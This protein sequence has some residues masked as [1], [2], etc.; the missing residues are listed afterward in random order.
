[1]FLYRLIDKYYRLRID[2]IGLSLF[3]IA[4]SSVVLLEVLQLFYFRA[5]VYAPSSTQTTIELTAWIVVVV[6]LI[7]GLGTRPATILNYAFTLR[8][9]STLTDWEYH[10]DYGMT[11]MNFILMF[12]PVSRVL[13]VDALWRHWRTRTLAKQPQTDLVSALNY[14]IPIFVGVGLVYFDSIFHKVTS[15]IWTQGLGIWVPSSLPQ[16]TWHDWSI[17]LNFELIALSLGYLTFFFEFAFVFCFWFRKLWLPLFVVGVGLHL[18]ILATFPIPLFALGNVSF[19]ILLVPVKLWRRLCGHPSS[20]ARESLQDSLPISRENTLRVCSIYLFLALVTILHLVSIYNSPLLAK[21]R[22]QSHFEQT[23]FGTAL[24]RFGR[25]TLRFS[26]H[27]FGITPHGVFMDSH[28]MGYEQIIALVHV[29]ID[30]TETWLPI[31]DKNGQPRHYNWGRNWVKWTFRTNGPQLYEELFLT[32]LK[33]FSGFWLGKNGKSLDL[34]R[35]QIKVKFI[36]VP[37]RWE[38]DFLTRQKQSPWRDAGTVRWENG[39]FK[40]QCALHHLGVNLGSTKCTPEG[41][42]HEVAPAE[43]KNQP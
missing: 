6:C 40:G 34:A 39:I 22:L 5:M 4:Y 13:S 36:K 42:S 28:F 32:G 19:Y 18:G 41:F 12:M 33:E 11:G 30:G 37:N 35:F 14:T 15:Q 2:P 29:D 7:V 38:K 17:L 20:R 27:Y 24:A 23:E 16:I 25:S 8:F 9:V 3:R 26:R 31:I 1:M 43:A 21:V 10:F